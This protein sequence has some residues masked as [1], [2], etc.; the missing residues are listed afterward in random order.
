MA[1]SIMRTA[2]YHLASNGLAKRAVQT[3]KNGLRKL[4]SGP[5]ELRVA[6]FFLQY[7]ITRHATTGVSSSELLIGRRI[8]SRLDLV[9]PGIM[10]HVSKYQNQ[11]ANSKGSR[12]GTFSVGEKVFVR[13]FSSGP[14]WIPTTV[15]GQEGDV[16]YRCST[17]DGIE[18]RRH[19]DQ[20]RPRIL[21]KLRAEDNLDV[22][23]SCDDL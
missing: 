15:N 4:T 13:N 6:Q 11:Q 12:I 23:S 18:V 17:G 22:D 1:L 14:R 10:E 19:Y 5:L 16:N 7:R 20:M 21:E 2:P 8:Q 3:L 9:H